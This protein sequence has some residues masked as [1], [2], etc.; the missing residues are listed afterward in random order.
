[1]ICSTCSVMI[2]C[3]AHAP[4]VILADAYVAVVDDPAIQRVPRSQRKAAV[5][6]RSRELP[7]RVRPGN[8]LMLELTPRG[9]NRLNPLQ[10]EPR[11]DRGQIEAHEPADLD[12]WDAALIHKTTDELRPEAQPQ[13]E[14]RN[15]DQFE[16]ERVS[17]NGR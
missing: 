2:V 17:S 16:C 11:F 6:R 5:W 8:T 10:R 1:M 3:T 15:I 14:C 13:R 7:T 9:A 4:D 12:E